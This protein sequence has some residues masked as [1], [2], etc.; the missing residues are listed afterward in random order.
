MENNTKNIV[1][2][3]IE[4]GSF[5]TL[6]AAVEAAGLVDTLS[7]E[8]PFTV[9]APTDEAF[10][11]LPQGTVEALLSDKAKLTSVLTYHVLS[12]NFLSSDIITLSEATT[13]QGS[14]L[15]IDASNGVRINNA[16]VTATDIIASNGVIHVID[17]VLLPE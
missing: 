14:N 1:E 15:K 9:L 4:A 16:N 13:V 11:K 5:K 2:V 10:A 17:T 12:G 7:S 6:V 3:A 8:G